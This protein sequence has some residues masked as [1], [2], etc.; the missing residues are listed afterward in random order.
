MWKLIIDIATVI[1]AID[2]WFDILYTVADC[3]TKILLGG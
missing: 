3:L 2:V 1:N